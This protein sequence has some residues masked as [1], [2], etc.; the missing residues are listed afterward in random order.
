MCLSL[1]LLEALF[2]ISGIH[3][4]PVA[5]LQNLLSGANEFSVLFGDEILDIRKMLITPY[6]PPSSPTFVV[7]IWINWHKV[8][9]LSYTQPNSII[10][11]GLADV[12]PSNGN[13][14]NSWKI[15]Q[16][17]TLKNHLEMSHYL[18]KEVAK[19]KAG[20]SQVYLVCSQISPAFCCEV[21]R[22]SRFIE[23]S[24][25]P[26]KTQVQDQT[27]PDQHLA[28]TMYD[29]HP[30]LNWSIMIYLGCNRS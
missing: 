14:P 10:D 29:V 15:E 16:K 13:Q 7:T 1:W 6:R 2:F 24:L 26:S 18:Q 22:T 21:C 17:F 28:A 27:L 12:R 3:K 8:K 23:Q 20:N 5:E 9:S 11:F 19:I 4:D 30:L 25:W